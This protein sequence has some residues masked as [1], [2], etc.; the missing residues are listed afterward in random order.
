MSIFTFALSILFI[1]QLTAFSLPNNRFGNCVAKTDAVFKL[2]NTPLTNLNPFLRKDTEYRALSRAGCPDD[3]DAGTVCPDKPAIGSGLTQ[4]Y[5]RY[6]LGLT[7]RGPN[8]DCEGLFDIDPV[9]YSH[10]KGKVGKGFPVLDFAPTISHFYV[11]EVDNSIKI[12][13]SVPLRDSHMR[14]IT[15][16]PNTR[17]DDTP[18]GP[19]CAGK[20][21]KYDPSGLDTEDLARIP[22]TKFVAIVDEYSP[23]VV[24][25]NYQTGRIIARHVPKKIGSLLTNAKYPIV[26]DIPDVFTHRRK[27]RGFEAVVVDKYGKYVITVLQ[28]PMLGP[29]E[30]KTIDNAIIRCAY[31]SLSKG[32]NGMPKMS[33]KYSFIIEASSP[34]TYFNPKNKAKDIKYSA[35]Q[36]HSPNKFVVLERA[37]S[38]V[39][40]FLVDFSFATSLEETEFAKDLKLEMKT[41]GKYLAQQFNVYPA[42]KI[43]IWDSAPGIG[44]TS[45]FM[46]SSKMEGFAIDM[47]DHSKLWM[48]NDNDFGL[49]NSGVVEM[50]KFSLG[51]DHKGATV[52]EMPAHPPSPPINVTASKVI[53]LVNSSTYRISDKPG[54]GAAENFDINEKA[55]LAY[56]ANDDTRSI[57]VYDLTTSPVTPI[58]NFTPEKPFVPTSTS[59]CSKNGMVAAGLKDDDDDAAPGKVVILTKQGKMFRSIRHR[60]CVQ[61]DHVKWSDDCDFLVAACEGEGADILGGIMVS[62]FGGPAGKLYR[63]TKVATFKPFDYLK[64][65]FAPNGVR[66]VESDK[67]SLDFEPEY[68]TIVDN[69]AFVSVQENNFI[70]VVDL[71]EAVVTELK[72][73]GYINRNLPGFAL[74]ASNKDGMINIRNYRNLYGMP[75][76]DAISSYTAGDGHTYLVFANEGDAKDAEE[77]RGSDITDVEELGRTVSPEFKV[78]VDNSTLLGR[79]KITKNMGYNSETNTQESMFHF[80]ARSFSIMAMNGTIVFDSGEWFARI[81]EK[82]FPVIFNANGFDDEDLSLSTADLKDNRYVLYFVL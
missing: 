61:V 37:K 32:R 27:N 20:K 9:K 6:F 60:L 67:A 43:L 17:Y 48:I 55:G 59:V 56:V 71:Y 75:Q 65:F 2:P 41:N 72:P 36:Y 24:L 80:G 15:G 64:R 50:H 40:L 68:V 81:T 69:H 47:T 73:I 45:G 12:V 82:H 53:S 66:L 26:N 46:G 74:D 70:A 22:G 79:L 25:A 30:D 57:D 18:Y 14:P 77:I 8:Q 3:R 78:V 35:A 7:D 39:K 49:K 76:P 51:R 42:K 28:S 21:L 34:K 38:Q 23:S 31:F 58:G 54:A 44:G 62:D 11:S 63:G 33:Y 16:L 29:H 13:N 10:A 5:P 4:L 19:N 52:C 1:G